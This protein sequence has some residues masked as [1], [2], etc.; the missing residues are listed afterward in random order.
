MPG[1]TTGSIFRL[2]SR[3][4]IKIKLEKDS[5]RVLVPESNGSERGSG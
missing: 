2:K 4:Q 5:L 3:I 1:S